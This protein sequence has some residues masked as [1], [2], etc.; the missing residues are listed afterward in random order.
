[1]KTLCI[2]L[3]VVGL[4]P[5]LCARY[6]ISGGAASDDSIA[7]SCLYLIG[8][9]ILAADLVIFVVWRLLT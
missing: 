3:L 6:A 8:W 7:A 5:I 1:M 2:L 9:A 4:I